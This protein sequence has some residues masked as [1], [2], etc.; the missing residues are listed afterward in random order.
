MRHHFFHLDA[1]L[2]GDHMALT[3]DPA[4]LRDLARWCLAL[5]DPDVPGYSKVRLDPT[6]PLTE[7][8]AAHTALESHTG[9]TII[10][11]PSRPATAST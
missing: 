7:A 1:R 4:G 2:S 3:G 11:V 9:G 5:S 8:V 10:L 6:Y